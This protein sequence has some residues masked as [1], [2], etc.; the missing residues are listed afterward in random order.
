MFGGIYNG[1]G[2]GGCGGG[3]G[4]GGGGVREGRHVASSG[5]DVLRRSDSIT[6]SVRIER[7]KLYVWGVAEVVEMQRPQA[8]QKE[9]GIVIATEENLPIFTGDE[10]KLRQL[11]LNLISNAIKYNHVGGQIEVRLTAVGDELTLAVEDTGPGIAPANLARL[12]ERFYRVPGSEGY[13]EGTGLGLSIAQKI[14]EA[15]HGRIQV[16]SELGKGTTFYCIFTLNKE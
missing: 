13:T 3:G 9:I 7:V 12:F 4:G 1:G 6:T 10:D 2:C 14:V 5:C 8:A 11:L 15:H 16:T